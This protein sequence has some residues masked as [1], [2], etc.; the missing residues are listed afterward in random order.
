MMNNRDDLTAIDSTLAR[1]QETIT[2]ADDQSISTAESIPGSTQVIELYLLFQGMTNS[3]KSKQEHLFEL[4]TK[5]IQQQK[6]QAV[7]W[8]VLYA[9]DKK[10]LTQASS[11][12]MAILVDDSQAE[13]KSLSSSRSSSSSSSASK[14]ATSKEVALYEIATNF[15][16]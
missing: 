6:T 8:L 2:Q 11:G 9:N 16:L 10:W 14:E 4:L 1:L 7:I 15:L 13:T 12:A 5:A 3:K